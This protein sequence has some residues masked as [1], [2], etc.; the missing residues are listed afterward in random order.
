MEAI[1]QCS[2]QIQTEV[3]REFLNE[4]KQI[5]LTIDMQLKKYNEIDNEL[6]AKLIKL[7]NFK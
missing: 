1:N 4:S 6:I 7:I 5:I 3:I 2:S